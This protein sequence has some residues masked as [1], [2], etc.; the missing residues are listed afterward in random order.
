MFQRPK[1]AMQFTGLDRNQRYA[2]SAAERTG[3]IAVTVSVE[4]CRVRR[5]VLYRA[6]FVLLVRRPVSVPLSRDVQVGLIASQS[7]TR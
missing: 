1:N 5:L 2:H 7:L 6:L 4:H 3:P